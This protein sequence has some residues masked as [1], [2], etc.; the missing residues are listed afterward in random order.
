MSASNTRTTYE[1]FRLHGGCGGS[2]VTYGGFNRHPCVQNATDPEDFIRRM[3]NL[4]DG[5]E[6]TL[7]KKMK[8][9][10]IYFCLR[11]HGGCGGTWSTYGGF[12]GHTC[13]RMSED[14]YR[15][16]KTMYKELRMGARH[17]PRNL[18]RRREALQEQ[19][20]NEGKRRVS[21]RL[22]EHDL[23]KMTEAEFVFA[24]MEATDA[25]SSDVQEFLLSLAKQTI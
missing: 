20:S 14:P 10:S 7:Q 9:L 25:P 11:T 6:H 5:K 22:E 23:A 2:W 13:V 21:V 15:F 17:P 19:S 3:V 12:S 16:M 24:A 8:G 1:C 4:L 18:G